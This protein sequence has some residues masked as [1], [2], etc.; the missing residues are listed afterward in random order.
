MSSS[1]T[2]FCSGN[3]PT[4]I[5]F[6]EWLES[7]K[8]IHFKACLS[9]LPWDDNSTDSFECFAFCMCVRDVGTWYVYVC[10]Q[11]WGSHVSA[12]ACGDFRLM[13]DFSWI[14]SYHM[15]CGRVSGWTQS[16]SFWFVWLASLL[17]SPLSLP[18]G[19]WDYMWLPYVLGFFCGC[20]GSKLG[21]PH[22]Y[23]KHFT[24]WATSLALHWQSWHYPLCLPG[25]PCFSN[26]PCPMPFLCCPYLMFPVSQS[27]DTLSSKSYKT[28][29]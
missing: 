21:S 28:F 4:S 22:L 14:V 7:L 11:V 17:L 10:F 13:L 3:N 2:F 18:P 8:I 24:A 6:W 15:W 16:V 25:E 23:G 20:W 26:N 12:G 19:S 29:F 27:A 9:S 5:S 1:S